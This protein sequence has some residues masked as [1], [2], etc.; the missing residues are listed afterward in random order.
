MKTNENRKPNY[1]LGLY[2][3]VMTLIVVTYTITL[4]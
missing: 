1:A 3:I 4:I 2:T